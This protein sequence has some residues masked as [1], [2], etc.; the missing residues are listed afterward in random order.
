MTRLA[1]LVF[2]ALLVRL[3]GWALLSVGRVLALNG[4]G[5]LVAKL[6]E[7]FYNPCHVLPYQGAI[8]L[9]S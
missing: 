6:D 9:G 1:V 4:A 2:L 5:L 3:G 7:I 8:T